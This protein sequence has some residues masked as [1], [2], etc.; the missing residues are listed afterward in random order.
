M[1]CLKWGPLERR[2]VQSSHSAGV[3][4]G[5]A[6]AAGGIAGLA[7]GAAGAADYIE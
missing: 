7:G 2:R 3:A 1:W 5:A 6:A 4:A